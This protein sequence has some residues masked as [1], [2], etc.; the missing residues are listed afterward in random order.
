MHPDS[1]RIHNFS[2]PFLTDT[3]VRWQKLWRIHVCSNMAYWDVFVILWPVLFLSYNLSFF[4]DTS[5][6][7]F[8]LHNAC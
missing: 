7:F 8:F 3:V 5:Q 1:G 4:L 6:L 2:D